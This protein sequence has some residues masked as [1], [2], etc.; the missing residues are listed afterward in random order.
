[1]RKCLFLKWLV[2][3]NMSMLLFCSTGFAGL[4]D[5]ISKELSEAGNTIV[6][7]SGKLMDQ[8]K[9]VGQELGIVE[10]EPEPAKNSSQQTKP[11]TANKPQSST[12]ST[13]KLPGGV[14]SRIK[15]MHKELDKVEKKLAKGAGNSVD[16]AN[17]AKLDLKKAQKF[18]EEIE[19]RYRGKYSPDN[20]EMVAATNRLASTVLAHQIAL[21]EATKEVEAQNASAAKEHEEKL[22]AK[23]KLQVEEQKKQELE[24]AKQQQVEASC[25]EWY[26]RLEQYTFGDKAFNS[27][28][29]ADWNLLDGWKINYDEAVEL[30]AK[31]PVGLCSKADSQKE[32]IDRKMEQF[33]AIYGAAMKG[34]KEASKNL[35]QIVFDTKPLT[36]TGSNGKSHFSAGE[37]IY[38]LVQVTK[39]FAEIFKK[40]SGFSIRVDV[41]IDGNKIHAQFIK[42]K[43]PEYGARNTLIFNVAPEVEKLV[44]YTDSNIEYGK[45]TPVIK[46]GPNELSHELGKLSP[47]T[48]KIEFEIQYYGKKWAAGEF[49]IEGDDFQYYASLHKEIAEGVVAARTLPEAKMQNKKFEKEMIALLKEAGWENV[50]RLNII[51]KDW[52]I[53]RVDGGNTAVKARY[54]AAVALT[55]SSDGSYFYK[56]CTFHQDR[57]ITGG[58]SALYLSHQGTAVPI[59]KGNIDK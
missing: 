57:L 59:S 21:G 49:T 2:V 34:K 8:A 35:G 40:K 13:G 12:G 15:K 20:P 30:K 39:P 48:H 55:E 46:Q 54:M 42:I 58:F 16:R 11:V 19:S 44:A 17:R 22:A 51:D 9:D 53:E 37:N 7:S 1:M 31:Y 24:M 47:G 14:T 28:Q 27:Y 33:E 50:Y 36:E 29:T 25:D 4:F 45:S 38:G 43:T 41:K 26:K 23:R 3:W 5:D 6:E 10:K 18:M 56:K 32:V 52:W